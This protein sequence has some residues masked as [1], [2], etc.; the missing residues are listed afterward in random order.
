MAAGAGQTYR[1]RAFA[2]LAGV[3]V[4]AL[5]HY[6]RLGLLQ[7]R[8]TDAGYRLYHARDLER[9]EQIVA[10][11]FLGLPLR[12]IKVLLE[13]TALELPDALRIQRRVLEQKRC[14]LDKA[15][16]AIREAEASIR[17][18]R[19]ADSAVL[20]RI[21]EVIEM[22]SNSDWMLQ[23]H[24]EEARAKIEERRKQWTPELQ[25]EGL[26]P[27]ERTVSRRGSCAR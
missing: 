7:P 27:V 1:A 13:Q 16:G 17:A 6:D 3:T 19:P 22:E 21:I 4:R 11:K 24:T 20:K 15:I 23:Y 25:A 14:L 5:H 8:R 2:E 18:G 12:R 10:L 9:L 26:A